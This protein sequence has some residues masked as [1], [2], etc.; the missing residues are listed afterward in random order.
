M[1]RPPK[2]IF[3]AK[4]NYPFVNIQW[5]DAASTTGYLNPGDTY[6]PGV[7]CWNIG[8]LVDEDEQFYILAESL[9]EDGK[10]RHRWD[11]PK[12]WV[13]KITYLVEQKRKRK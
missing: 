7:V 13:M 5:L 2:R 4:K 9:D 3:V 10:F 12:S 1:V 8:T 11:I 6:E